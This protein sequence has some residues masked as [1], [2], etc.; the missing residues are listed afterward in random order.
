MSCLPVLCE[1][2]TK[3]TSYAFRSF[4]DIVSFFVVL[5]CWC[6]QGGKSKQ[7][8]SHGGGAGSV[9]EYANNLQQAR[10]RRQESQDSV[11]K[12]L[13]ELSA[14]RAKRMRETAPDDEDDS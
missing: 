8:A 1:E 11:A 4:I 5:S 9:H 14:A 3:G 10:E 13:A 7:G 2:G 6:R 12:R